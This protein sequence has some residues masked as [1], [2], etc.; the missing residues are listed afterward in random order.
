MNMNSKD[1][2][3]AFIDFFKEKDHKFVRSSPVVPIDD[4]TL[5]FTNAGMNQFKSIFLDQEQPDFSRVVNSQKCIR[6]SGKHND[7]EEVGVDTFHHTFFEMLGNWSF[8]DYYKAEAIQWAWELFTEVWGLDKNRLW[9]TVYHEDSEAFDLWPKVTDIAPE[10]VLKFD[11]KDNFWE[12]GE[13]GPCGP[14][15]EIHYF[16]GE[17]IKSQSP[18]G[19]NASD[20]YW[21]LW[22]LVFIQ[23]NRLSNGTLENLNNMH[24]DTGAGFERIVSVMQ[25][26]L[27]NYSTDLFLPIIAKIERVTGKTFDKNPVPF[28]V[29]S[30]HLRMLS[31]AIADGALPSNEGRGY[32]VR[33]ILRR[34]AR[35]GRSLDMNQPFIYDLVDTLGQI[36]GDTFPEVVDKKS[37][38]EKII[39]AEESSFNDTLDRGLSHF[40]KVISNTSGK[41]ITGS[42]AFK[43]YDTYG[44]PLDLTQ[45]M[46]REKGLSVDQSGFEEEMNQ[47]KKRAKSA[48]KFSTD[49]AKLSWN[50][51]KDTDDSIFKG[52]ETISLSAEIV[53]YASVNESYLVVL[54]QT[55]FYAESGG[56][57]GDTGTIK[58]KGVDLVV[59][60][61]QLDG[62]TYV[63]Y[64][65]GVLNKDISNVECIVDKERRQRIRKNHTATHLMH[66]A[67][68]IVLGDHVQQAGSLVHPDYL[69]FDLTHSEKISNDEVRKIEDI[70]NSEVLINNKLEVSIKAFDEAKKEG[71]VA[72]FG[73][74]Y[75]DQVRV[76]TVSDF[77]KELCGG[78]HVD[79]TGDIGL[80]KIIEESSLA[81]G[82]R[83]IVAVTGPKAVEY[84]Q[85]QFATLDQAKELLSC[86]IDSISDRLDQLINDK[87]ALE[88]ELKKL[89]KSN[90]TFDAESLIKESYVFNDNT[91]VIKMT[92]AEDMDDLKDFG[93]MLLSKLENGIGVLAAIS[94]KPILVVV[95]SDGLVK[96][97]LKAGDL[98]QQVGSIMGG[99]G[100]GRPNL[101]TAGGKDKKSLELAL[102]KAK[103]IIIKNIEE[104]NAV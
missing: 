104:K 38:I 59:D 44:F 69:R 72:M 35:F 103:D 30:D 50:Q 41:I 92:D 54:D 48:K 89:K 42:E 91:I 21:E 79:R 40:N 88:R 99:G 77:S 43:L 32:V 12:M 60:D 61:V 7:L 34:A 51:L 83:R 27:S 53:R 14:C 84:I 31:F 39:N 97:G 85:D 17:D 74:K 75:G 96:L 20:Q 15:S 10:R 1:I 64:C 49:T 8:G 33:R 76:V 45:L 22:N 67:L 36:M 3:N 52:Y 94:D 9:V 28:Q 80:F 66:Q 25:G 81:S 16:I 82:V 62:N 18:K 90:S 5:L 87:K 70:V 24:V 4:P 63:H 100:G 98:A 93:N 6:V 26:Q 23:H 68:K 86:N 65:S 29:I 95:V 56:Q 19:V 13:T 101:A 71:A 47:Q 73:E 55:P 37:H 57:I 58:G 102:S 78:T 11:K 46:A 2:R